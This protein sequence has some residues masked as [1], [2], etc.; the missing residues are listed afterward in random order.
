MINNQ[1]DLA[2]VG[3]GYAGLSCA[4]VAAGKGLKTVVF[5]RKKDL[6]KR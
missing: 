6:G 2:I 3:G 1:V 4:R 5:D